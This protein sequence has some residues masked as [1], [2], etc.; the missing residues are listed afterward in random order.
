MAPIGWVRV[1]GTESYESF[2]INL[3]MPLAKKQMH[4]TIKNILNLLGGGYFYVGVV[5]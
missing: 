2:T 4:I 5:S 3:F 1:V